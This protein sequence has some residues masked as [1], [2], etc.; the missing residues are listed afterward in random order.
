MLGSATSIILFG[1]SKSFWWAV[2]A[3]CLAGALNGNV[4]VVKS[5]IAE[6]IP[7]KY[8]PIAF[9]SLSICW[10]LG[11]TIGP[12]IG[13]YLSRPA[14]RYPE[15]FGADAPFGFGGLWETF[16]YFLPCIISGCIT[17]SAIVLG[18][19]QLP[20]TL[21][22]I[23]KR[24]EKQR[25][26]KLKREQQQ[27]HR[28][29][30]EGSDEGEQSAD[31][32]TRPLLRSPSASETDAQPI[33]RR[34]SRWS[35]YG[36]MRRVPED[37]AASDRS[38]SN[39]PSPAPEA[40]RR[41]QRFK[42][43]LGRVSSFYSGW[44]PT[45]SQVASPAAEDNNRI[46]V[47]REEQP[48]GINALG[49]HQTRDEEEQAFRND[50]AITVESAIERLR[51]AE[52]EQGEDDEV[53]TAASE[54]NGSSNGKLDTNNAQ[55][56]GGDSSGDDGGIRRLLATPHIQK[57]L[58]TQ[59]FLS[60]VLVGL[61]SMQVLYF[62]EPVSVGGLSLTP[63]ETGLILSLTGALGCVSQLVLFPALQRRL[64]SLRL[65]RLA[66]SFL[67]FSV[68]LLPLANVI[69]RAQHLSHVSLTL[70]WE[71][72][73]AWSPIAGSNALKILSSLGFAAN[74]LLVN[75]SASLFS[76]SAGGGV[77]LGTLNAL[78]QMAS[79]FTRAIGPF[80]FS[81][82]LSITYEK[83]LVHGYAAWGVLALVGCGGFTASLGLLDVEAMIK[84]GALRERIEG[85]DDE[86]DEGDES[87]F[88]VRG[89]AR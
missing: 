26:R 48:P 47:Q 64:G 66:L 71:D 31:Q 30:Q 43:R 3:R 59:G 14:D 32:P 8:H 84:R 44:T 82:L 4:A 53:A 79:S 62:Y 35:W 85:H 60:L 39:S 5:T 18:V 38:A 9:S 6:L 72:A 89:G 70:T 61:D 56:K 74:M 88:D 11:V 34:L 23:V 1:L 37:D 16:P 80:C 86:E 57:L 33:S 50:S 29:G 51:E 7:P 87:H 75:A 81:S 20:E 69:A 17:G 28:L 2:V 67:P 36:T 52:L 73:A 40:R 19:T 13:G 65:Y 45:A 24:R 46:P 22:K 68:L 76:S 42:S 21:P 49:L 63:S 55:S 15:T 27:Q 41:P 12:A 83:Q 58:V 25:L 77:R 54:H 78:A 10:G